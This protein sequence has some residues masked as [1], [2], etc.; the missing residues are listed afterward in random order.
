MTLDTL[1]VAAPA[2]GRVTTALP[3]EGTEEKLCDVFD[4]PR[5]N[6]RLLHP[7]C[8][9]AATTRA[10]RVKAL[11]T[12]PPEACFSSANVHT[13]E[14]SIASGVRMDTWEVRPFK[15]ILKK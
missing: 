6:C 15:N 9:N 2:Y 14:L 7:M 3:P 1:N 4:K 8:A 11:L 5:E 12:L 13:F 10:G